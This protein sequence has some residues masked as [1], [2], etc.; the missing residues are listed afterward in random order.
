MIKVQKLSYRL[1]MKFDSF[2]HIQFNF[3]C[4]SS[5]SQDEI[6]KL[7][8]DA[9]DRFRQSS[10]I[11]LTREE[12]NEIFSAFSDENADFFESPDIFDYCDD[13]EE[14]ICM[15]IKFK[16]VSK[17][18]D[19]K[20]SVT[21]WGITLTNRI[22]FIRLLMKEIEDCLSDEMV[23]KIIKLD[24]E[25]Y[26]IS[27]FNYILPKCEYSMDTMRAYVPMNT[28]YQDIKEIFSIFAS[29]K[30]R[31]ADGKIKKTDSYPLVIFSKNRSCKTPLDKK[32]VFITFGKNSG[33]ALAAKY[34]CD[35]VN[36]RG[37]TCKF[38][39]AF[40]RNS[41]KKDFEQTAEKT[42]FEDKSCEKPFIPKFEAKI[43]PISSLI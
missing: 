40:N 7:F 43:K 34:V 13:N 31:D 32:V 33:D 23:D 39:F 12:I 20:M 25:D 35:C 22:F 21:K 27:L 17:F 2:S 1:K 18:S 42:I 3:F 28:S 30:P 8:G 11:F 26:K 29:T 15:A 36:V 10:E 37:E 4:D 38:D 14:N 41:V 16:S 9:F 19:D 6:V 24:L 5:I